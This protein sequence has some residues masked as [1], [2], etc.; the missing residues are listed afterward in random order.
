MRRPLS[1]ALTAIC[2]N[3]L[4]PLPAH[5]APVAPVVVIGMSGV[6][7]AKVSPGDTPH[8][9][10]FAKSASIGAMTVR[11]VRTA[12]C[13]ESGWLALS[14][15][16]RAAATAPAD[17]PEPNRPPCAALTVA[18]AGG[19]ATIPG[20]SEYLRAAADSS[21]GA[22]LGL[23]GDSLAQANICATAVGPGAAIALADGAGRVPRYLGRAEFAAGKRGESQ[24]PLTVVD[25]G[26]YRDPRD[27]PRAGS[28]PDA[29][30]QS[31][32]ELD[33]NVAQV[34]G[35]TDPH[36]RIILASLADSGR[37]AQLQVIAASGPGFP[38]GLLNTRSTRQSALIQA[39]DLAPTILALLAAAA[40]SGLVGSALQ[41]S[42]SGSFT[43]R[44]QKVTDLSDSARIAGALVAPFFILLVLAQILLYAI[45]A[46]TLRRET[47]P[48][49]KIRSAVATIATFFGCVPVATYWGNTLPWW[50]FDQPGWRL[51]LWILLITTAVSVVARCGPWR[52]APLGSL[53]AVAGLTMGTM[54]LDVLAGSRLQTATLMGLQPLVAGRFYGFGNLTYALYA[55][56]ALLFTIAVVDPIIRRGRTRAAGLIAAAIGVVATMID[57]SPRWGSDFG[58]P[59]G[60]IPAFSV[61]TLTILGVRLSLAKLAAIGGG[62]LALVA[63]VATADWTRP[64]DERTHLGRFVQS[65]LDGE[66]TQVIARKI[67]GN[68]SVL[69][70]SVFTVL[71]PFAVLFLVLVL[72][73]PARWGAPGLAQAYRQ[74][75]ALRPGLICLLILL[76]L[77]FAVNDS[78]IAIPA[79]GA[80]LAIP[81]L[82]ALSLGASN[83]AHGHAS[84]EP[85]MPTK[86]ANPPKA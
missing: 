30:G 76:G 85:P 9:Y 19:A 84:I 46:I 41:S 26:S 11:T 14:S 59:I 71:V 78:G 68:I 79:V 72:F 2:L 40:P 16:R 21:Y 33:Q 58:G 63:A 8:I 66:T 60:M 56:A 34:L 37:T 73:R 80:T 18:A 54:V 49:Q 24:C 36:A 32:R 44:Q 86:A 13:P 22:K 45:A 12:A 10:D 57:V 31:L 4:H 82:T 62:T 64:P 20:W 48:T 28:E 17:A 23:L 38:P 74:S 55:T 35:S 47:L 50:R 52:R 61:L 3:L 51:V 39:T 6:T 25:V 7:W 75:P 83:P 5:A 29:P 77:G 70:S 27:R 15:G 69:T 65:I 1:L 53:G 43:D 67:A 42:A 81:L